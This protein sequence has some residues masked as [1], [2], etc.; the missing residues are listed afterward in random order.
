LEEEGGEEAGEAN[1]DSTKI[2]E[3][4]VDSPADDPESREKTLFNLL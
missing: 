2:E 1:E 3:P 4:Q